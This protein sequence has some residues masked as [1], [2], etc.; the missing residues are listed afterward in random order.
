MSI[1][2]ARILRVKG[3]SESLSLEILTKK[4][5]RLMLIQVYKGK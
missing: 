4:K 5:Y 2:Q 1:N 3:K